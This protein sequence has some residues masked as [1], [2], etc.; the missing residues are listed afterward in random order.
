MRGRQQ[1]G[2]GRISLPLSGGA[3]RAL[4]EGLGRGQSAAV[5]M[6]RRGGWLH[7]C[8]GMEKE[9]YVCV[10]VGNGR[11]VARCVLALRLEVGG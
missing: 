8:V 6:E 2:A 7:R 4:R 9:R 10:G 1:N 11:W 5:G 3:V